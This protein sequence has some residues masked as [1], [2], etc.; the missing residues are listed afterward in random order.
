MNQ[1]LTA[2][3][4]TRFLNVSRRTFESLMS[5]KE[6]PPCLLVG[7]QRRWRSD[8]VDAWVRARVDESAV[9]TTEVQTE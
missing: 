7:R 9:I 3:A 5:K 2:D 4:V 8:D 1:L 6:G